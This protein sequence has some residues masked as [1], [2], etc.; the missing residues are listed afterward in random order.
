MEFVD[1]AFAMRGPRQQHETLAGRKK[2]SPKRSRKRNDRGACTHTH[3]QIE[4]VLQIQMSR[5]VSFRLGSVEKAE[6][7]RERGSLAQVL[8]AAVSEQFIIFY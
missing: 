8:L 3:T 6:R 7:E 5:A 1:F 4:T 2:H